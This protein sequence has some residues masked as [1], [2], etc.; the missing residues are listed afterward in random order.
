MF[1]CF[2]AHKREMKELRELMQSVNAENVRTKATLE[3]KCSEV[4]EAR[5][6]MD[7]ERAGWDRE[8]TG[9][10]DK[11]LEEQVLKNNAQKEQKDTAETLAI[12]RKQLADE[13]EKAKK[14]QHGADKYKVLLTDCRTV[15]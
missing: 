6:S 13:Q 7:R 2:T 4:A 1:A 5:A 8:R 12:V 10:F 14:A 15:F 11:L 3:Q 9:L